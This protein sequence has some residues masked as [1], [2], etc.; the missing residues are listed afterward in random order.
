MHGRQV[1]LAAGAVLLLY[2]ARRYFRNWGTTKDECEMRLPGDELMKRP[3]LQSTEGVSIELSAAE[4]WPWL[5][6]MGQGRGGLYGYERLENS[7]G[8]QHRNADRI[9]PEWQKLDAGDVIRL[10]PR[11][12]LGISEGVALTV[13]EV[14]PGEAIVLHVVPPALPWETV[15]SFHLVPHWNDRCR[16]LVRTRVGLRHPG[17]VLL[18]ELA[19][20]VT[21]LMTRGMLLGIRRRAQGAATHTAPSTSPRLS[22]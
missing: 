20:P 15:W 10:A 13:A 6:Q 18:A 16:L 5:V 2:G 7:F 9:H 14:I 19:S 4:V 11:G 8:L 21:A 12:W 1:T 17:E 22:G 3:L